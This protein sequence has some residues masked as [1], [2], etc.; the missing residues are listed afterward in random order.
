V[1]M[2]WAYDVK[3]LA[4]EYKVP[5]VGSSLFPSARSRA[6]A[7]LKTVKQ[8]RP[9][10]NYIRENLK[11]TT[12]AVSSPMKG[13]KLCNSNTHIKSNWHKSHD[14]MFYLLIAVKIK[15]KLFITLLLNLYLNF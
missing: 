12:T 9:K 3:G 7:S 13:L 2:Q 1:D 4:P 6:P 10:V 14:L 11:L 15:S 5:Q 8:Q